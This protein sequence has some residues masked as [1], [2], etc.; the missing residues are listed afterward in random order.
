MKQK[1]TI[2][3]VYCD[4]SLLSYYDRELM[5][6]THS[7]SELR[8]LQSVKVL[9]VLHIHITHFYIIYLH[10]ISKNKQYFLD[11]PQYTSSAVLDQ[12]LES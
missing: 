4:H 2:F 8:P 10:I 6:Q 11:T 7:Q 1:E 3:K 9:K 12:H 5:Y